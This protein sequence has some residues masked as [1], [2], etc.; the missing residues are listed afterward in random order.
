MVCT[1]MLCLAEL[2]AG[3]ATLQPLYIDTRLRSNCNG[4]ELQLYVGNTVSQVCYTYSPVVS[5]DVNST[6][7]DVG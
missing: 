4:K 6:K 2:A 1:H 7:V 3:S 5:P